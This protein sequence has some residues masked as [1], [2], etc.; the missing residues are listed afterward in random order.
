MNDR[1]I[2][3]AAAG[4]AVGLGGLAALLSSCCAAPW[5]VT[6]FGIASAAALARL[7]FLQT[8]LLAAAAL[9]IGGIFWLA[10]RQRPVVGSAAY[11]AGDRRLQALAWALATVLALLI[12]AL[13]SRVA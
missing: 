13:R 9:S 8:Y 2:A 6:L 10:F 4:S 1:K 7:N 3:F 12:L 11:R 5:A